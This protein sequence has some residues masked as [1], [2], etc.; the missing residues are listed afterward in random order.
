M[1]FYLTF[2][3]LYVHLECLAADFGNIDTCRNSHSLVVGSLDACKLLS[4]DGV[5]CNIC[6][7]GSLDAYHS[8]ASINLSVCGIEFCDACRYGYSI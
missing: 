2:I 6:T 3:L 4:T 8:F 5:D 1:S 7:V